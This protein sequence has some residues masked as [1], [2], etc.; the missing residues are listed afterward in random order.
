M[1]FQD[2]KKQTDDVSRRFTA[3]L[4]R[5]R[6]KCMIHEYKMKQDGELSAIENIIDALSFLNSIPKKWGFTDFE[7]Y[8]ITDDPRGKY[9]THHSCDQDWAGF[10]DTYEDAIISYAKEIKRRGVNTNA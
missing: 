6:L 5:N 2:V 8:A 3:N 7:A 10:G 9:V 4:N 1:I